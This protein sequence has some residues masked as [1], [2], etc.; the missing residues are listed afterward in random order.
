MYRKRILHKMDFFDFHGMIF[1]QIIRVFVSGGKRMPLRTTKK[2]MFG[3]QEP[4]Y[5]ISAIF[6]TITTN[7]S[8][9]GHEAGKIN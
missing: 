5:I 6:R 2:Y 1:L 7:I 4:C 3:S 9:T 8:F